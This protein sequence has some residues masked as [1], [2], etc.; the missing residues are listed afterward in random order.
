M[1]PGVLRNIMKYDTTIVQWLAPAWVAL[2]VITVVM[3]VMVYTLSSHRNRFGAAIMAGL[4]VLIMHV[5]CFGAYLGL[6]SPPI[7][8]RTMVVFFYFIGAMMIVVV[9]RGAW[10]G[11]ALACVMAFCFVA[12]ACI[13][14]NCLREQQAFEQVRLYQVL[15]YLNEYCT[16]MDTYTVEITGNGGFAPSVLKKMKHYKMLSKLIPN[17]LNMNSGFPRYKFFSYNHFPDNVITHIW[18]PS[19][20]LD[21]LNLPKKASRMAFDVY[22]DEKNILIRLK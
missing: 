11:R 16:T 10:L 8:A 21:K 6:K 1:I 5:V 12:F 14:S 20:T 15:N 19:L 7:M 22:G 13:Y 3:F 17:Y 9:A 2:C 18:G 4:T